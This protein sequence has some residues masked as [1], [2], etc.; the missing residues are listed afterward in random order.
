MQEAKFPMW[1]SDTSEAVITGR[2]PGAP[3]MTH[4]PGPSLFPVNMLRRCANR[5]RC[6]PHTAKRQSSRGLET[7]VVDSGCLSQNLT[8]W[9]WYLNC[10]MPQFL[11]KVH[12]F[13]AQNICHSML[14]KNYT[15][16]PHC[17]LNW[18]SVLLW[19]M[20][21]ESKRHVPLESSSILSCGTDP[22]WVLVPYTMRLR[23]V[24]MEAFP[25]AW[26]H[27]RG[28]HSPLIDTVWATNK[29]LWVQCT[30]TCISY[31]MRI[32]MVLDNLGCVSIKQDNIH[33]PM[34]NWHMQST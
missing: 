4:F 10:A 7:Q 5:H 13:I 16:L 2:K 22:S 12:G 19:P 27:R 9:P 21:W 3:G 34:I 17:F 20:T 11:H 32:I 26:I 24:W 29:P 25:S 15:L 14:E 18:I 30:L 23:R 28:C 31:M 33:K 1:P 8:M 6:C